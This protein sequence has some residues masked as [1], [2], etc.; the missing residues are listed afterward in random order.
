MLWDVKQIEQEL[1]TAEETLNDLGKA[2]TMFGSARIP[3]DSPYYKATVEVAKA[4]AERGYA[5]ISGGGPG[6]MEAANR[7]AKLVNAESVGLNIVLPREQRPNPYQTRA[8]KFTQFTPRKMTFFNYS[9][10]YICMPGGFG[11]LDELFEVLTLIQTGKLQRYPV[12]LYDNDFWAQLFQW[13]KTSL[14]DQ[15]LISADTFEWVYIVNSA[16]EVLAIL[17]KHSL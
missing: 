9:S 17:D 7:G 13:F 8:L 10:A 2:V 14:M 15:K 16:E 4:I 3:E 12:M 6:I 1:K 5:I 11:T